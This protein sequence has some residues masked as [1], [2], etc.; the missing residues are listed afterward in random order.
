MSSR[1]AIYA[2]VSTPNQTQAQTIEEQLERLQAYVQDQGWSITSEHIFRD[3][4]QSGASLNR[5]G[6]DR[7]RDAVKGGMVERIVVTAPD[8]LARNQAHQR[9]LLDELER[10]GCELVLLDRPMTDDPH[11]RLRLQIRRA[12]AEYE[13]S[14]VTERMRRARLSH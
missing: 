10:F 1:V 2:R 6:L 13:R 12:V 11:D 9:V 8:R 14:L 5:P 7:L 3:D 4:G